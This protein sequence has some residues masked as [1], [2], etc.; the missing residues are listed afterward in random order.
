MYRDS[1]KRVLSFACTNSCANNSRKRCLWT[2]SLCVCECVCHIDI[3]RIFSF[4]SLSPFACLVIILCTHTQTHYFIGWDTE[5]REKKVYCT[6]TPAISFSSLFSF[7]WSK[8]YANLGTKEERKKK[9]INEWVEQNRKILKVCE[10]MQKK[11]KH[12][13]NSLVTHCLVI[14]LPLPLLFGR[15]KHRRFI[16]L[17]FY[18]S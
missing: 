9:K 2:L 5:N 14:Y 4:L 7:L 13:A 18:F 17:W 1:K 12:I 8:G 10:C 6:H 16:C 11:K 15:K 3:S